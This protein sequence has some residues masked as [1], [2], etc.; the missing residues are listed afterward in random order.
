M[1]TNLPVRAEI[2]YFG[3]H[4]GDSRKTFGIS[5][6]LGDE[7]DDVNGRFMTPFHEMAHIAVRDLIQKR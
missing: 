7:Q 3:Y 6:Y 1:R 5:I 4:K 2:E